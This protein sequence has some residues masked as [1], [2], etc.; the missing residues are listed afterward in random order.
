MLSIV[1]FVHGCFTNDV[2][3]LFLVRIDCD[4]SEVCCDTDF[5]FWRKVLSIVGPWIY[6]YDFNV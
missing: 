5:G 4:F 1:V 6:T 2:I 3:V